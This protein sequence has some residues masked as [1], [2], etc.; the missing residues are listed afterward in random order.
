[1]CLTHSFHSNIY[2]TFW[3][4]YETWFKLWFDIQMQS[5]GGE[6]VLIVS[7]LLEHTPSCL[8]CQG[9]GPGS[10]PA[11][12]WSGLFCDLKSMVVCWVAVLKPCWNARAAVEVQRREVTS[13]CDVWEGVGQGLHSEVGYIINKAKHGFFTEIGSWVKV[14]ASSRSTVVKGDLYC[15]SVSRQP[16]S[17]GRNVFLKELCKT[18]SIQY[19]FY[20][21]IK[22]TFHKYFYSYSM[23][24]F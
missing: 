23:V 4:T 10:R 13:L 8:G 24:T 19:A 7:P 3:K 16:R 14:N 1:M 6:Q 17:H 12:L 2:K 20:D 5:V 21:N 15:N 11:L 9:L 22:K 18:P